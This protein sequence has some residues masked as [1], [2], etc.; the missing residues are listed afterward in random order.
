VTDVRG[1]A[2]TD[3]EGARTRPHLDRAGIV[4]AALRLA[5]SP[6][7]DAISFRKL[8]AELGADP[9]AIYRHFADRDAL[10]RAIIDRLLAEVDAEIDPA[11]PWDDR[12]RRSAMGAL[13]QARR[14]PAVG[15]ELAQHTTGGPGERESIEI[16]LNAWRDSGLPDDDIVRFYAVF[17]S[18]VLSSAASVA[19]HVLSLARGDDADTSWLGDLDDLDEQRYPLV[20]QLREPLT[21][22]QVDDTYASGVELII[23]AARSLSRTVPAQRRTARPT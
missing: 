18:Y 16:E 6:V 22:L 9:T 19:G 8:G 1:R 2:R 15:L 3:G 17:S 5:E 13:R 10:M 21:A 14:Y 20:A 4:D 7:P 23:D 12:L 11:L